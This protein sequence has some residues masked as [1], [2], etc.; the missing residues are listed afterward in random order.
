MGT[1]GFQASQFD[2]N[3]DAM[4]AKYLLSNYLGERAGL[5]GPPKETQKERFVGWRFQLT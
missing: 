1:I 5:D 2:L 4:T 3:P